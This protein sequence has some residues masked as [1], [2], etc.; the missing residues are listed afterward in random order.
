MHFL[1]SNFNLL[2]SNSLWNSLKNNVIIDDNFN[3]Y[4]LNLLNI[5]LLNKYDSFHIMSFE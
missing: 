1:T 2:H 4:H 5:Q 3:S